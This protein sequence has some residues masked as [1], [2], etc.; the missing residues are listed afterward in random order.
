EVNTMPVQ[1]V[2]IG[3]YEYE[4]EISVVERSKDANATVTFLDQSG[5]TRFG[6]ALEVEVK[7]GVAGVGL[8]TAQCDKR[9][10]PIGEEIDPVVFAFS[11]R[12]DQCIGKA[13]GHHPLKIGVRIFLG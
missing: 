1:Y 7:P 2:A 4:A 6:H 5:D 11:G 8:G 10:F 9:N 12:N 13:A 3:T